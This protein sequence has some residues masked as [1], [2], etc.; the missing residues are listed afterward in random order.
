MSSSSLLNY[1]SSANT[2]PTCALRSAATL[3]PALPAQVFNAHN[4]FLKDEVI[5]D[6]GLEVTF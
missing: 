2:A 4:L 1:L 5:F 6:E 3:T